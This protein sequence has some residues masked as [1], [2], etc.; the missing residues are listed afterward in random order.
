MVGRGAADMKC[1]IAAILG[2]VKGLRSSASAAS[3]GHRGVGRRGGMLRQRDPAD[4]ARRLHGRRGG[5][6][7]TVRRGDHDL[8]GRGVVVQRPH[9]RGAG[10]RREGQHATN[11]IE[12][13]LAVIGALI[14]GGSEREPPLPTTCSRTPSTS[15]SARSGAATTTVPGEC[16]TGY[17]IA[18]SPEMIGELKGASKPR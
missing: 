11:A 3:S 1:G 8:A 9:H 16:E 15:T 5:D 2:A 4:P 12:K 10:T 17:R 14:R 18:M 6:R 13:S 7:G